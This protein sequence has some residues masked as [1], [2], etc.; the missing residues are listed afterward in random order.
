MGAVSR[1]GKC[2]CGEQCAGWGRTRLSPSIDEVAV[3]IVGESM[4]LRGL[5]TLRGGLRC[6][7]GAFT[8]ARAAPGRPVRRRRR[9]V[10]QLLRLLEWSDAG[11]GGAANSIG[12]RLRRARIDTSLER[13]DWVRCWRH[14]RGFARVRLHGSPAGGRRRPG[15]HSA[16]RARRA[17]FLCMLGI[18]SVLERAV[19]SATER[20]PLRLVECLRRTMRGR[21]SQ[22]LRLA[23]GGGRAQRLPIGIAYGRSKYSF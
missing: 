10:C 21:H 1:Y 8:R 4:G 15:F 16:F 6:R 14:R 20:G 17:G 9:R 13:T 19:R 12:W 5:S 11:S 23:C 7:C 3:E 18:P 22:S 2:K